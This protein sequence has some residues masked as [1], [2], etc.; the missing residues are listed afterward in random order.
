MTV[1]GKLGAGLPKDP[2]SSLAVLPVL[3]RNRQPRQFPAFIPHVAEV[4]VVWPNADPVDIGRHRAALD[5]LVRTVPYLG[6]SSSLVR[7]SLGTDGR[8]EPSHVPDARGDLRLCC[9]YPG[10]LKELT[11]GYERGGFAHAGDACQ[12]VEAVPQGRIGGA[13]C[14]QGGIDRGKLAVDLRKTRSGLTCE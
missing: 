3:R 8:F 5:R 2:T 9:P 6:H 10:R 7:I 4:R 14:G 12:D 1:S 11:Q 13:F